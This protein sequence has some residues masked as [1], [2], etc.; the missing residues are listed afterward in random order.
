MS[1]ARNETEVNT[2]LECLK[3]YY[4]KEDDKNVSI[5]ID[6]NYMLLHDK[7][8]HDNKII[9]FLEE[10]IHCAYYKSN[11]LSECNNLI[12]SSEWLKCTCTKY[13]ELCL[14]NSS[15]TIDKIKPNLQTNASDNYKANDNINTSA[16]NNNYKRA[17][18]TLDNNGF[19]TKSSNN[20]KSTNES[21]ENFA[22][23]IS[24]PKNADNVL[25]TLK[26]LLERSDWTCFNIYNLFKI[27][28]KLYES[29]NFDKVINILRNSNINPRCIIDTIDQTPALEA[30]L[31][32]KEFKAWNVFRKWI[33][34]FKKPLK[35]DGDMKSLSNKLMQCDDTLKDVKRS[36]KDDFETQIID[37]VRIV[38]ETASAFLEIIVLK[39]Q[40]TKSSIEDKIFLLK[41]E[42]FLQCIVNCDREL[43]KL[44][45]QNFIALNN[46]MYNETMSRL[47]KKIE[48]SNENEMM[49]CIYL[50]RMILAVLHTK[51][52]TLYATQCI[53]YCFLVLNLFQKE[54]PNRSLLLEV[55]TGEGKSC[56]LAIAA[57]TYALLGR[58]VDIVTSSPQLAQRDCNHWQAFFGYFGLKSISNVNAENSGNCYESHIV[59]GT[60]T[61]FARDVLREKF[62]FENIRSGREL[63]SCVVLIDE[64]DSMLLDRGLQSTYLS[65]ENLATGRKHLESLLAL[66]WFE[67][68]HYRPLK[69]KNSTEKLFYGL[70]KPLH[71]ILYDYNGLVNEGDP[72]KLLELLTRKSLEYKN[73]EMNY[74]KGDWKA[75]RQSFPGIKQTHLQTMQ[76]SETVSFY[77][78]S[79]ECTLNKMFSTEGKSKFHETKIL[80][81]DL[82]QE[83]Q[84]GTIENMN[85][86]NEAIKQNENGKK[87]TQKKEKETYDKNEIVLATVLLSRIELKKSILQQLKTQIPFKNAKVLQSQLDIP[88]YLRDYVDKCLPHWVENA[89]HALD[90][91]LD[92]DYILDEQSS[93]VPVDYSVSGMTEKNKRWSNGLQQFLE[94]KH[95][96]PISSIPFITN[97]LSHFNLFSCYELILGVSGTIFGSQNDKKLLQKLYKVKLYQIPTLKPTKFQEVSGILLENKETWFEEIRRQME[98][99]RDNNRA[100]LILCEDIKTVD[101]LKKEGC[102]TSCRSATDANLNDEEIICK[103]NDIIVTTNLGSRGT[104]YKVDNS[105]QKN[106][107]LFVIV[108]F[109]PSSKRV[110]N[111][112]FGRTARNGSPG[113][114][115]LIVNKQQ[116]SYNKWRNCKTIHE[117]ITL[118]DRFLDADKLFLNHDKDVSKQRERDFLF[119]KYCS[120]IR[121]VDRLCQLRQIPKNDTIFLKNCLH[122][123]WTIWLETNLSE[124]S[125][126]HEEKQSFKRKLC[127]AKVDSLNKKHDEEKLGHSTKRRRTE[128]LVQLKTKHSQNLESHQ[129]KG[130]FGKDEFEQLK[131]GLNEHKLKPFVEENKGLPIERMELNKKEINYVEKRFLEKLKNL[132][133]KLCDELD[134]ACSRLFKDPIRLSPTDN[135]Y[136]L[137]NFANNMAANGE[138]NCAVEYYDKIVNEAENWNALAFY[139][140][141]FSKLSCKPVNQDYIK[142]ARIDLKNAK[143]K[144]IAYKTELLC[145]HI[146]LLMSSFN[147][148]DNNAEVSTALTVQMYAEYHI[149]YLLDKNIAENLVNLSDNFAGTAEQMSLFTEVSCRYSAATNISSLK[150][151]CDYVYVTC[152]TEMQSFCDDRE[153]CYSIIILIGVISIAIFIFKALN[154]AGYLPNITFEILADVVTSYLAAVNVKLNDFTIHV[155]KET[156]PVNIDWSSWDVLSVTNICLSHLIKGQTVQ[157]TENY[158]TVTH[159]GQLFNSFSTVILDRLFILVE[160]EA[161]LINEVLLKVTALNKIINII[162]MDVKKSLCFRVTELFRY[163]LN[164]GV[165]FTNFVS[166][167][168]MKCK[169][170]DNSLKETT[171]L[172][173]FRKFSEIMHTQINIFDENTKEIINVI[174]PSWKLAEITI[175]KEKE[176]TYYAVIKEDSSA[177]IYILRDDNVYKNDEVYK[178]LNKLL[179]LEF[180]KFPKN[181]CI[182]Q[183]INEQKLSNFEMQNND[184]L[185]I[186]IESIYAISANNALQLKFSNE[187]NVLVKLREANTISSIELFAPSCFLGDADDEEY[188]D[189]YVDNLFQHHYIVI[190][191]T[192][193]K[194]QSENESFEVKIKTNSVY[195]SLASY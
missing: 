110:Q 73:F 49:C 147:N 165:Q 19:K 185:H 119:E 59:Y 11:T 69:V 4:D 106:C 72:L 111:Q 38:L 36:C 104:D 60:A 144:L 171:D 83:D 88:N 156:I 96:V 12:E 61:D 53:S 89:L 161:T 67:V 90:M 74:S 95:E 17:M 125:P 50:I 75:C 132:E 121:N 153:H 86:S 40:I 55:K 154:Y 45:M 98:R 149:L 152:P 56:I 160:N 133:N 37:Q 20:V 3:T 93:I 187:T 138:H 159:I 109:L 166:G 174:M 146:L 68:S 7:E 135:F 21:Y 80:V 24:C 43:I 177:Y 39:A 103:P 195:K 194:Q 134:D 192:T 82:E 108:T 113:S 155:N 164:K 130:G 29:K 71:Q 44:E 131:T 188:I 46:S 169:T 77:L 167:G 79:K 57:A 162:I 94:M 52:L 102:K 8:N 114:A 16:N 70:V 47:N 128:E 87:V 13:F 172:F 6:N 137:L 66:V 136:H 112:A 189:N 100:V 120:Y 148:N 54:S 143:F 116:L 65:Y 175:T 64:V 22:D 78:L 168:Q 97:F 163:K 186:D 34:D 140:R 76:F 150:L 127:I 91:D 25:Y 176:C 139:R 122:E 63:S 32:N 99:E 62:F 81:C 173:T 158:R 26:C 178:F 35:V 58:K 170:V 141:A 41:T 27:L 151:I 105:V 142:Q 115:I 157:S 14:T 129:L 181:F 101:D 145:K 2:F 33:L 118:R 5:L 179:Q 84:L 126:I 18:T 42:K 31:A 183:Q 85:K 28:F 23:F 191:H 180:A 190:E 15:R 30:V 1:S 10:I 51:Q 107:G 9:G 182:L 184:Q 193:V 48:Q 123:R 124:M 92:R 117:L